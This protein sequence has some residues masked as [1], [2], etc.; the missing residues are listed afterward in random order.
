MTLGVRAWRR[1]HLLVKLVV[2]LQ[3]VSSLTHHLVMIIV[4][5]VVVGSATRIRVTLLLLR[6]FGM[7]LLLEGD[8]L[9]ALTILV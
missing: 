8:H 2:V 5:L 6:L 9:L 3:W 1:Y 4:D 7:S